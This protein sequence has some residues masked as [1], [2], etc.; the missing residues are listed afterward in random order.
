[1][2]SHPIPLVDIVAYAK[3]IHVRSDVITTVT[4]YGAAMLATAGVVAAAVVD[5]LLRV[6]GRARK[7]AA[8]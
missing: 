2:T 5:E 4:I 6:R 3:A 7:P 8:G 1:M